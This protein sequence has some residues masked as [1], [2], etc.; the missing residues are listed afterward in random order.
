[1]KEMNEAETRA[2]LIDPRLKDFGWEGGFG[3]GGK[4]SITQK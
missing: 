4:Q 3:G 1:L 2:E